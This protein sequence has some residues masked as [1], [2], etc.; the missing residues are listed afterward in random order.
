MTI[1]NY[2]SWFQTKTFLDG[3]IV[4]Q[5]EPFLYKINVTKIDVI[6]D[7][8]C[9]IFVVVVKHQKGMLTVFIWYE[10]TK[11][12]LEMLLIEK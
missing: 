6:M 8:V 3:Y 9:F 5:K 4:P 11:G 12:S 7:C 1:L 10:Q 2:I